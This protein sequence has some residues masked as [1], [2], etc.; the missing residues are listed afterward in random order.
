VL[1]NPDNSERFL[2]ALPSQT[3]DNKNYRGNDEAEHPAQ[4]NQV[5]WTVSLFAIRWAILFI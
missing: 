1:T 3:P 2:T 5:A 4:L